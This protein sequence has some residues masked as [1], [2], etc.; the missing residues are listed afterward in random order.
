MLKLLIVDDESIIRKGLHH[1]IDWQSHGIEVVG[2][3]SNGQEGLRMALT[4][5][6][7]IVVSD[8]R[9]PIMDGLEMTRSIRELM[10]NTKVVLLSGHSDTEYL[11]SAIKLNTSDFVLKS[12]NPSNVL[13]AVLQAKRAIEE[14]VSQQQ[15][16]LAN[17]T[18]IE[19]NFHTLCQNFMMD[20]CTNEKQVEDITREAALLH[21]DLKGPFYAVVL[22]QG[23]E[24]HA[25]E[26][27]P[28]LYFTLS[29]LRPFIVPM[30]NQS[31][32]FIVN[33][34]E[35][36]LPVSIFEL[37]VATLRT[38]LSLNVQFLISDPL[39]SLTDLPTL[40]S[41]MT[42]TVNHLC[43]SENSIILLNEYETLC[44]TLPLHILLKLEGEIIE[45]FKQRVKENYH[46]KI[47]QFH[48]VAQYYKIAHHILRESA[49]RM[50]SA[51]YRI[52]GKYED[53]SLTI[54]FLEQAKNV[55][56]IFSVLSDMID[57]NP[58]IHSITPLIRLSLEYIE[59]NFASN[60]SLSD[61]AAHC[62][63][64]PSYLSRTFKEC[65]KIGITEYIREFRISKA[66]TLL[67]DNNLRVSQIAS[68]IGYS[69]YKRFSSHFLQIV[70]M[71]PR[72]YRQQVNSHFT[73]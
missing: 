72:E 38:H 12:A 69:D 13:N 45:S 14:A 18:I 40:Y 65:M 5:Q 42:T 49:K 47:S 51:M 56:D 22:V 62:Y 8:I 25:S 24:L 4:L 34:Q 27:I 29:S 60:L 39:S 50:V 1:Y 70:G 10:P 20:L 59:Q 35:E 21:I 3:A 16:L 54:E 52:I 73:R 2:E 53:M 17:E 23:N 19:K 11:L 30:P 71:S 9:M 7:N 32:F 61:I 37:A 31:L 64:T 68:M 44:P 58:E 48:E 55:Q 33:L 43:W 26:A 15:L 46:E 36:L 63:V 41:R 57:L 67:L 66:K 28:H 6:P